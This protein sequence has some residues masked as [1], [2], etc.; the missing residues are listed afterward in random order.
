MAVAVGGAALAVAV[1]GQVGLDR[2]TEAPAPLDDSRRGQPVP[3][4][5]P[6]IPEPLEIPVLDELPERPPHR[7][8]VVDESKNVG[9][10]DVGPESL[11]VQPEHD[12][13]N[14]VALL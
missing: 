6:P 12:L 3:R 2:A 1:L 11:A 9:H 7:A 14:L 4:R 13:E 8:L 10:R 5:L